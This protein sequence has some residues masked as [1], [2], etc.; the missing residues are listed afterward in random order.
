[1]DDLIS[2]T[3]AIQIAERYGCNNGSALGHHSGA[4]DC[5]ASEIAALPAI[6][7]ITVEWLNQKYAENEPGENKDYDYFLWDAI[8]YILTE[9]RKEQE[10]R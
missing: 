5:I 6:D 2:R 9:W 1:M 4:A 7:A 8:A 10:A 3:A